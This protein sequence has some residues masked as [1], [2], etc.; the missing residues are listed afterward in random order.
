MSTSFAS[1]L[2]KHFSSIRTD[3]PTV[4]SQRLNF[5]N[6]PGLV[7]HITGPEIDALIIDPQIGFVDSI[8]MI[9][10]VT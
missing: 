1:I 2:S 4:S 5:R 9:R 7:A 10:K 6:W 8:R 3:C